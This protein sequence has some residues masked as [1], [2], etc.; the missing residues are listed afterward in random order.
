MLTKIL[1]FYFDELMKLTIDHL[2]F[3]QRNTLYYVR[4]YAHKYIETIAT[5]IDY[6]KFNLYYKIHLD[7]LIQ[8]DLKLWVVPN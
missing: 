4:N 5:N 1:D 6:N 8:I 7:I 3:H 2:K